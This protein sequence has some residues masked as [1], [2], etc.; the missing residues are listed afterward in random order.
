MSTPVI[1]FA[2]YS[3]AGKTTLLRQLIARMTGRGQRI[4]VVKHTH[5]AFDIDHPGK[6]SYELRHAGAARIAIGS[7]RR[8]ALVVERTHEQDPS[9]DEM[10]RT[11]D[12]AG[13]DFVFVEGFR[14]EPFAKIEVHRPALGRPLLA[15]QDASIIAVATDDPALDTAARPRLDLN[16]IPAI[17]AFLI[18]YHA[19]WRGAPEPT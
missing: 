16:D 11:L 6:D 2:G 17:E 1:G 18:D 10:L 12:P 19:A 13:L 15:A 9:L 4:G 14:H 5:H 7:S 8:Y 3:G